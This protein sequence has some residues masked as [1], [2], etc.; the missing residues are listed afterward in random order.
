MPRRRGVGAGLRR[1]GGVEGE[2]RR[3]QFRTH[4]P[5]TPPAAPA[6]D[7]GPP[8]AS[9]LL[10]VGARLKA[11][12]RR[13]ASMPVIHGSPPSPEPPRRRR[14][15][16]QPCRRSR[17]TEEARG[18]VGKRRTGK[19][20]LQRLERLTHGTICHMSLILLAMFP[21]QTIITRDKMG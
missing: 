9:A 7:P 5:F 4:A 18:G 6:L 14:V 12:D 13:D 21:N 2:R 8:A 3:L 17:R 11:A 15:R 10:Q 19:K 1:R 16:R 20:T